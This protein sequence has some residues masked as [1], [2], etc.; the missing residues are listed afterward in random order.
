MIICK[1]LVWV[2]RDRIGDMIGRMQKIPAKQ[3]TTEA[4]IPGHVSRKPKEMSN[5]LA[6][7]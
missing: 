7:C 3:K 6:K 2:S 1:L 4:Q 5:L